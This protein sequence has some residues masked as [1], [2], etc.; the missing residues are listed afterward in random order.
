MEKLT[1]IVESFAPNEE[2]CNLDDFTE[3]LTPFVSVYYGTQ[4]F[5]TSYGTGTECTF[6]NNSFEL[7]TGRDAQSINVKIWKVI[8]GAPVALGESTICID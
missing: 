7:G 1:I 3:K 4:E 2:I 5:T 8:E 6:T